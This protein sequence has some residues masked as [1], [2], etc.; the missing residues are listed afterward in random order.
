MRGT[1]FAFFY[2]WV[3]AQL[4]GMFYYALADDLGWARGYYYATNIFF[5]IGWQTSLSEN[6]GSKLFSCF[7][8]LCGFVYLAVSVAFATDVF[9][10][11][12]LH[13]EQPDEAAAID[14]RFSTR[15][16]WLLLPERNRWL[17][18][19]LQI[20]LLWFAWTCLGI[21]WSCGVQRWTFVDGLYFALSTNTAG[22]MYA[23]PDDAT[24]GAFV[25]AGLYAAIGVP[26]MMLLGH[27]LGIVA[28]L[29]FARSREEAE[30]ERVAG[31]SF[32][33][34]KEIALTVRI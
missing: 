29:L 2:V 16:K 25:A 21:I 14:S 28:V 27:Q 34:E 9:L 6:E 3:I 19:P 11:S 13:D 33:A 20:F 12:R 31:A 10:V 30:G 32:T 17:F 15:L 5:C 4:I 22:G 24:D 26:L 8:L 1:M 7:Y 18:R 23:L